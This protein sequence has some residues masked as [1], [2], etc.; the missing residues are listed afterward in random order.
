MSEITY[1][2]LK[3]ALPKSKDDTRSVHFLMF[4]EVKEEYF[5]ADIERAVGRMQTVIE[6][7]RFIRDQKTISL[8]TPIREMIII[9][10]DPIFHADIQSLEKYIKEE[11][12]VRTVTVTA[13][14]DAFG[15]NYKLA[16][17]AKELGLKFKKDASKIRAGI[18]NVTKDE[19]KAFITNGSME[20]NGFSVTENEISVVRTFDNS[21][22]SYHAHFTKEVLVILDTELDND[23]LQEGVAREFVNRVQRLRKKAG[24]QQTDDVKYFVRLTNDGENVLKNMF[25]GQRDLLNNYLRQEV[26]FDTHNNQGVILEEEQDINGAKFFLALVK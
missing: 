4:P 26:S 16:P 25:S 11:M 22:K 1:Q 24:L 2:K 23:L 3:L 18:E 17:N 10:P 15:V 9:N 5:N 8:K 14:E 20:I 19:I 21:N 13:D 12:N 6:L 7:G